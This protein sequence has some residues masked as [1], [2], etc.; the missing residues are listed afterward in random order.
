MAGRIYCGDNLEVLSLPE[1][2]QPEMVDLVYLDPPFNSKRTWNITY[3][4]SA[5]QEEAFKDYWSWEEAAPI[6]ARLKSDPN[7]P[8]RLKPILTALHEHLIDDDG[9]LLAY[10]TMM[11]PRLV[12]LHRVLKRTGSMYLHCDANASHY[13]KV[14]LDAIFGTTAFRNEIIWKRN[15][16][17]SDGKQGAQHLGRITDTVL[18]YAKSNDQ[19]FHQLY[20]AYDPHYIAENYKRKDPDGRVYRVDNIQGPGGAAKGNPFYEFLGVSRYW[21]YS[22]ERMQALY[23]QGRIIQ[24]SAG[25]VPQYKRYLD[26]MPGVPLQNLWTDIP[27]INNRS[28]EWLGYPTQKPIA[29]MDRILSLSTNPGDIVLDPFCGCG[30]TVEACERMGRRWFGIDITSKAIKVIEQ[31]F[32]QVGLEEPEIVWHPATAQDA[33]ELAD[34]NKGQFERWA[35]RKIRAARV[36]ARDRG[37]DGEAFF[38]GADSGYHVIVSVKGGGVKPADVRDLRGTLDREHAPIGVFVTRNEPSDEMRREAVRLGYL[39][40]SDGEGQI[41][42]IQFVSI[43]R[44]FGPLPPI[45]VPDGAKNVTEMPKPTIPPPPVVG[46]Q[47]GLN[48]DHKV[49]D[50]AKTTAP[51]RTRKPGTVKTQPYESPEPGMRAVASRSTIPPPPP[52][53]K[54]R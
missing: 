41:P 18:F 49:R 15:A 46:E 12:A 32:E 25:A 50:V 52:S 14:I 11:A 38:K 47:L 29:L 1:F 34:R 19:T 35:I 44:M 13:L 26:E 6:F 21:R 30:T 36:R 40:A 39:E 9:D 27:V 54:K 22:R 2:F 4:G 7:I 31:R 10:L 5:A 16:A 33:H 42:R 53:I 45:R 51:T 20:S 8:R 24:T 3:K 28:K 23:E 43:E 17:H 37:I 48:I